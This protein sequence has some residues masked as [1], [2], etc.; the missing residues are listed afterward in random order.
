MYALTRTSEFIGAK[1]LA[2]ISLRRLSPLHLLSMLSKVSLT[3]R[4]APSALLISC[5]ALS[6]HARLQCAIPGV[7]EIV[8]A[9]AGKSGAAADRQKAAGLLR[10]KLAS[11]PTQCRTL[12]TN[13]AALRCLCLRHTFE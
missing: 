8:K 1:R 9:A 12:F 5:T 6:Y 4:T 11:R 13:A 7:F 2:S 10:N 3:L